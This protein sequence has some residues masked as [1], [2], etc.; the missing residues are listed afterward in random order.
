[1]TTKTQ[2][3][4]EPQPPSCPGK[5]F[6]SCKGLTQPHQLASKGDEELQVDIYLLPLECRPGRMPS[7][8]S[9]NA[10]D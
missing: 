2:L 10:K 9:G 3:G 4:A 1:M 6:I 5:S 7:I 8:I